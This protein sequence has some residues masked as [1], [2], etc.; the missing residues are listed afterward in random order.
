MRYPALPGLTVSLLL[1][2][3]CQ[4]PLAAA[5]A[6]FAHFMVEYV[7]SWSVAKWESE[8]ALAQAAHIDGFA[9]NIRM[10]DET[11]A[12]AISRAFPAAEN[13]GF[14]LF[15]SFDYAGGGPWDIQTIEVFLKGYGVSP[16]HY[17]HNG[18]PLASTFEG[19][20]NAD[21]WIRI[22][23]N[24]NAFFVPD[25]SSLG[26]KAALEKSPGVPN[27][28][29]SWAS[30][31][32]G[33]M[34]MTTYTDASYLQ[35]LNGLPYMMP[36][37]PWFYTNLPG[38]NKNWIWRGDDLWYDRWQQVLF[39]QPEWVQ[40][41]TWNDFGESSYIG[42]THPE[43][44][45]LF[46]EYHGRAAFNYA[47]KM[48]H[49][50]W[51]QHIL[52]FMIDQ[53]K[54][55]RSTVAQEAIVAWYRLSPAA[56]CND[57]FTS[58]NTHTQLQLEFR[59][60]QVAQDKIF[61]SALLSSNRAVT[62]TVGGVN[63]NA[64]W[65]STP[66]GGVGV[67]HGSVSYG[68]SLG[69]VV[70]TVG[71]MVFNGEPITTNC[72]RVTNQNGRTNWNAWVGSVTGA[73]VNAVAPST[74]NH[75]CIRGKGVGNF[76][77]LCSFSCRYGYCPIGACTCTAKGPQVTLPGPSTPGYGTV[78]YPAAGLGPSYSGL[79][80]FSCNYGYCPA[81]VCG[82]TQHELIIP[83]VSEF[84]PFAC[85]GGT[86]LGDL[87][88]LCSYACNFG[89][90]PMHSCTCTSQGPLNLPPPT[91][92]LN[93]RGD[94]ANNKDPFLYDDLCDFA[95][96]RGYCPEGPCTYKGNQDTGDGLVYGAP[97][98]WHDPTPRFQ[99][100][101]PCTMVLPPWQIPNGGS[102]VITFPPMT[103]SLEVGCSTG[104]TTYT[105][106]DNVVVTEVLLTIVTQ[107]TVLNIPPVT[108]TEINFWNIEMPRRVP[109]ALIRLTTSVLPP[110]FTVANNNR[111]FSGLNC[112]VV[113]RTIHPPPWPYTTPGPTTSS[114]DGPPVYV[115]FTT[116]VP[117]GGGCVGSCGGGG[118]PVCP[119][120]KPGIRCVGP[121]CHMPG[122]GPVPNVDF[123][124]P[125]NPKNPYR[126]TPYRPEPDECKT[127]TYSTCTRQ[128][129]AGATS[130]CTTSCA[131]AFKCSGTQSSTVGTQT[132]AG[133][134][135]AI[136]EAWDDTT[137]P[138][139]YTESV[140]AAAASSLDSIYGV[141]PNDD[142]TPTPTTTGGGGSTPT[143]DLIIPD[144]YSFYYWDC[145]GNGLIT[146]KYYLGITAW[147]ECASWMHEYPGN[148]VSSPWESYSICGQTR[149]LTDWHYE[150]QESCHNVSTGGKCCT[151]DFPSPVVNCRLQWGVGV[152]KEC[153]VQRAISCNDVCTDPYAP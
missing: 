145:R 111:P 46:D 53:Y 35:Y 31:P 47:E 147:G 82:T 105:R 36:V 119:N 98:M 87:G 51:R 123:L 61:F 110:V 11:A 23:Q 68:G 54:T 153:T 62:V 125:K 86:G 90:C 29:F 89:F 76:N 80:S 27:G 148:P 141:D 50:A 137:F 143:G 44:M 60:H 15:F 101:P 45:D 57:G 20:D 121:F 42:P 129:Y 106:N 114:T 104:A 5:K 17:K 2:V 102:T 13:R 7:G 112:P 136:P 22:K 8:M 67:Y 65:T 92:G 128:C 56:A 126:N 43:E 64:Q 118:G 66:A 127:Q 133:Y 116:R 34:D 4:A 140:W 69:A 95:C 132:V 9:L 6:V 139:E 75:V 16:A 1:A 39:V 88:G 151:G 97:D 100:F 37:S 96:S 99:C 41:I 63:L 12:I 24:T 93:G 83:S 49:D 70:I 135:T 71:S 149:K 85:T 48:P 103:T 113:S 150:G 25:W 108:T 77:G 58:G 146:K 152:W 14:K 40:I 59:P 72:N 117:A 122:L 130:S 115:S 32:W 134:A 52:P 73:T 3:A 19:P 30:W 74:T 81:G 78:G 94:P 142:P 18:K 144:A 124:D 107:T 10:G 131:T 79:C 120:C 38:Y 28:L 33:D 26:A 109:Y 55:N 138:A 91:I 84:L 21:D